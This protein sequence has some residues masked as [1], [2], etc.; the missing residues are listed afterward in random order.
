MQ[1][2]ARKRKFTFEIFSY[3][4]LVVFIRKS[5]KQRIYAS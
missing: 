3:I 1:A 4:L 2:K 5:R